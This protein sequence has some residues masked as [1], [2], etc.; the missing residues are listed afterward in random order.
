[1]NWDSVETTKNTAEIKKK[2]VSQINTISERIPIL[3][4]NQAAIIQMFPPD[5]PSRRRRHFTAKMDILLAQLVQQYGESEWHTIS[6]KMP[7]G[8]TAKECRE[9]WMN[10]LK[11]SGTHEPWTSEEDKL[12][13]NTVSKS[14]MKWESME[15]LFPGRRDYELRNRYAA[16]KRVKGNP[17]INYKLNATVYYGHIVDRHTDGGNFGD[18]PHFLPGL[19]IMEYIDTALMGGSSVRRPNTQGR[20]GQ[21]IDTDFGHD[22]GRNGSRQRTTRMSTVVN[23]DNSVATAFPRISF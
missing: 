5:P 1:M 15:S 16:L 18:R 22:I 9:R 12:L 23:D 7:E 10:Y 8:Y 13:L 17:G 6:S 4:G 20:P 14:G 11:P 3:C 2:P 21:I 19:G